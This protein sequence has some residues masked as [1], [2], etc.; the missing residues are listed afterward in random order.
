MTEE[1]KVK[2]EIA[3]KEVNTE[4]FAVNN[5]L[6]SKM[7]EDSKTYKDD[8]NVE[9]ITIPRLKLVQ[10]A[11]P[12][13]KKADPSYIKGLEE[14]DLLNTLTNQFVKGEEGAYIV[15]V[16]RKVIF[17]EWGDIKNGG[18]LKNNFGEDPTV[19]DRTPRD[20]E[21]KKTR[22]IDGV[23]TEIVKTHEVYAYIISKD[24]KEV[25][26]AVLSL[27][28]SQEKSMKDWNSL[29]RLLQDPKTGKQLPEYAGL[30][31][32]TTVPASNDK[33]SWFTYKFASAGYSLAIPG[34]GT[35]VY[36]QAKEFNKT[37]TENKIKVQ[38]YENDKNDGEF[39]D[40]PDKTEKI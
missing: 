5:D 21:G 4:L 36:D 37:I 27:S 25:S 14:G 13:A 18:G 20:A 2:N 40:T 33:G 7:V 34:I 31:M 16:K 28:K 3:K 12:Q 24:F 9:D 22:E 26:T 23:K 15:P 39:I 30:Y 1:S 10:S 8:T 17:L 11:T 32:V 35:K 19:Y 6:M 29:I 38:D